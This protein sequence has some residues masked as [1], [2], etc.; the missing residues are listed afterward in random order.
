[1]IRR[2]KSP[3]GRFSTYYWYTGDARERLEQRVDDLERQNRELARSARELA[4]FE[5]QDSFRSGRQRQ[6]YVRAAR[7]VARRWW[8]AIIEWQEA[9]DRCSAIP[10]RESIDIG[11][12]LP[13]WDLYIKRHRLLEMKQ[14]DSDEGVER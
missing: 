8:L 4:H 9:S 13:R 6:K 3:D 12:I 7:D 14:N 1:M 11:Y 5:E 10:V 2:A